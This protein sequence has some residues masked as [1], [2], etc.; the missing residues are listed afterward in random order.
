MD[1][2]KAMQSYADNRLGF[3]SII[4]WKDIKKI[5]GVLNGISIVFVTKSRKV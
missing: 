4:K 5:Y 3:G 1:T 2:L